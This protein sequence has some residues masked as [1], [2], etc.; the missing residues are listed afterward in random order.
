MRGTKDT[1]HLRDEGGAT[2]RYEYLWRAIPFGIAAAYLVMHLPYLPLSLEDIDSINFALGL[3]EFDP[4]RHQPHPPGYPIYI[5]FGRAS[6]ALISLLW[7]ELS[8]VSAEA[9]A[10]SLWSALGGAGAIV[11][12]GFVFAAFRQH[13]QTPR[14]TVGLAVMLLA[15]A[16]LFW[17]TGLRP[18]SDMPGLAV[19]LGAQALLL[20]GLSNP[21]SLI[22]G[23]LVTG[24]AAGVRSQTLWLTMPLFLAALLAHRRAGPIWLASRP[25]AAFAGG[26]AAW[27]V[28]LVILSGGF[29][30]YWTALAAQALDDRTAVDML[31]LNPTPRRLAEGIVGML[32]FTWSSTPLTVIMLAAAAVGCVTALARRRSGLALP[33]L[34]FGPYAAFHLAFQDPHTARYLLPLVP[35]LTWLAARGLYESPWLAARL[36]PLLIVGGLAVAV[37]DAMAYARERHPVFR[38]VEGIDAA[39]RD[40]TP[41]VAYA[42]TEVWRGLQASASG[43]QVIEPRRQHAWMGVVEYWKNGGTAPVWFFANPDRTDLALIDPQSRREV[44]HYAWSVGRRPEFSGTRPLA[45][46]RYRLARPGWFA[47]EGWS[48]TPETAGLA[49]ATG[50]GPDRDSI[51]A[52]ALRR[53]E[54]MHAVIGGYLDA[55]GQRRANLELA[56]DGAV[57]ERWAVT[58]DAPR[59]LRFL[60]LPEGALAGSGNYATLSIR[61][62]IDVPSESAAVFIRQF[63][64]QPITRLIYGFGDGWHSQELD[65]V[66]GRSWRWT[67]E[68]A[69]LLIKGPSEDVQLTVRGESPLR[70]FDSPPSVK[71]L[72]GDRVVAELRP[73]ADFEWQVAIPAAAVA[74]SGGRIVIETDRVYLPSVVEGTADQRRLGLRIWECRVEPLR[75]ATARPEREVSSEAGG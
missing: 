51:K 64:I 5:A 49:H 42:H 18:M 20:R 48:L 34:A 44:V 24:L 46:D 58:T 16:P 47:G 53:P 38:A 40:S 9:L 10:L 74:D 13:D 12:C 57:V 29:E 35:V 60:E 22:T 21:G 45:V 19:A 27:A 63:D 61:S 55:T 14:A 56:I 2:R 65:R 52:Y 4:T 59:F 66:S 6:L 67:S 30:P 62:R 70:Y 50:K 17:V 54:P 68:R 39:D 36:A 1:L 41:D 11:A 43:L 15:T 3:E 33:T 28:P 37:P 72:A 73:D 71:V 31:W 23:A 25:I 8:R 26:A 7:P 32:S 69:T 75:D